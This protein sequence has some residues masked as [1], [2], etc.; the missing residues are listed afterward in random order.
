MS[1]LG[2][3]AKIDVKGDLKRTADYQ[4]SGNIWHSYR[5]AVIPFDMSASTR[6]RIDGFEVNG[7]VDQ[8]TRDANVVEEGGYGIRTVQ[9]QKFVFSNLYLHHLH[10]DGIYVAG[11]HSGSIQAPDANAYFYNVT[12]TN[13]ARQGLTVIRL[14]GGLFIACNFSNTGRTGGAYGN[15]APSAGVDVEPPSVASPAPLLAGD[16]LF[17][18]CSF[19]ENLGFQF[20]MDSGTVDTTDVVGCYIRKTLTGNGES[21]NVYLMGASLARTEMCVFEV[22]NGSLILL[23]TSNTGLYGTVRSAIYDNNLFNLTSAG[24][25]S[26]TPSARLPIEFSGNTVNV[27]PSAPDTS[28]VQLKNVELVAHNTFSID[29]SGFAGNSGYQL[30]VQYA[31]TDVVRDNQY[32]TGLTI[33]NSQFYVD[34]RNVNS[35]LCDWF[36]SG[37]FFTP[38]PHSSW[39]VAQPYSSG[40]SSQNAVCK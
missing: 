19:E 29:G 16:L 39:V 9:C 35:V 26:S 37:T 18:L 21:R 6:F 27:K 3:G 17:T 11:Y 4:D 38:P 10:C 14:R 20:V 34:Y 36:L 2:Q 1:I 15:H 7:N 30:A 12:S 13:N 23:H 5:N 25:I 22:A 8:M 31:G 24:S 40:V 33:P 32:T 28:T